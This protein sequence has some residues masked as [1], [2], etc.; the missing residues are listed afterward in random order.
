MW[1]SSYAGQRN[2][3][4][5]AAL[6]RPEL[7]IARPADPAAFPVRAPVF[8][9]ISVARP[10]RF[11]TGTK[12][13]E[14]T[15]LSFELV[16]LADREEMRPQTKSPANRTGLSCLRDATNATSHSWEEFGYLVAYLA[17]GALA[18]YASNGL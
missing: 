14:V 4:I 18:T 5:V 10:I 12:P 3:A 6:I 11:P 13:C 8:Q 15:R 16:R 2:R 7:A 9:N 17:T 1:I